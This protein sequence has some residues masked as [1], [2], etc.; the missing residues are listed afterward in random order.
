MRGL[1]GAH[2]S[3]R[4]LLGKEA[5]GNDNVQINRQAYRGKRDNQ[6]EGLMAKHPSQGVFVPTQQAVKEPFAEA[7]NATVPLGS[8]RPQKLGA[9]RGSGGERYHERNSDCHT[10]HN[11]KLTE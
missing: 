4:I 7:V 2:D 3:S 10:Q 11:G 1:Y 6:R 8:K 5:F 9:H